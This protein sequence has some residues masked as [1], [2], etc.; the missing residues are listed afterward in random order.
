[1]MQDKEL[2][3]YINEIKKYKV[4]SVKENIE[5]LKRYTNGEK[6]LLDDIF[7]MN[8]LLVIKSV[9]KYYSSIKT[10]NIDLMDL[11]Q[12]GNLALLNAIKTYDF[13]YNTTFATWACYLIERSIREAIIRCGY[14]VKFHEKGY[15]KI[16][17]YNQIYDN[18]SKKLNREPTIKE[19]GLALNIK[20][21]QILEIQKFKLMQSLVSLNSYV[22]DEKN[23]LIELIQDTQS[24]EYEEIENKINL[25]NIKE[26][27]LDIL[28]K[29][30]LTER[31]YFVIVSR[32]GFLDGKI[33]TQVE[34]A[35]ELNIS[36]QYVCYLENNAI[37]KI[38]KSDYI[39]EIALHSDKPI[40]NLVNIGYDKSKVKTKLDK[41]NKL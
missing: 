19:L 14:S 8:A 3:N 16:Q 9:N 11:V 35:K 29:V 21:K 4:H 6:E 36:K 32:Y 41:L 34:I 5:Y 7:K 38:I 10:K 25:N 15:Q 17:K 2:N 18:L 28:N 31:E 13:S 33:R 22:V 26:L 39:F 12:Y 30:K 24:N 27:L 23:E 40:D 20:E 1:M 37:K